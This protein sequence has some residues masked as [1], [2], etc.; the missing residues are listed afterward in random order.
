MQEQLA[1]YKTKAEQLEEEIIKLNNKIKEISE[2]N[3]KITKKN[4]EEKNSEEDNSSFSSQK[5]NPL[6]KAISSA[7]DILIELVE[8]ILNQKIYK[9]KENNLTPKQSQNISMDVYE[10]SVYNDEE[11]KSLLFEQIQQILIFKINFINK[12][13]HLGLEK[14][15][16]RIKNWNLN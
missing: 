15:C 6:K 14:Q 10:P 4:E 5:K 8:L 1:I 13:Y 16:E 12:I 11:R 7:Y 2:K 9:D 3:E